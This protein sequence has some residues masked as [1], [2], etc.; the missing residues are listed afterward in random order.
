MVKAM[1]CGC[2]VICSDLPGFGSIV[3]KDRGII[4][5]KGNIKFVRQAIR[6]VKIREE[7]QENILKIITHRI[8]FISKSRRFI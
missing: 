7:K 6:I 4:A 1:V 8:R 5:P 3:N 2:P